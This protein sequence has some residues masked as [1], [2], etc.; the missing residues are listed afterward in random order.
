MLIGIVLVFLTHLLVPL[1]LIVELWRRD[2]K[3]KVAWLASVLGFGAYILYI[4]LA[5]AGWDWVSYYLRVAMPVA[6]ACAI[7][8]SFR[9]VYRDGVPWWRSPGALGGWSSL[10]VNAFLAIL[11]GWFTVTAVQGFTYGNARA[12]DLSFPLEG[13]VWHVAHGGNNPI[14]NYHNVNQS[15]R[16]ALDIVKLN[17]V[18]TR[19]SGVY[20]SDP[21]RYA[22]FEG[23]IESPCAGEGLLR[24]SAPFTTLVTLKVNL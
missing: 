7:Y 22:A 18:G 3:S 20:P 23:T 11:F 21:E 12:V 6:F 14:L 4:F 9:R 5:G 13:G 17:P 16:F 8:V 15:Q 1:W 2:F 19:A 10:S 24:A